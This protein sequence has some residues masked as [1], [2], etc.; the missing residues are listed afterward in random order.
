MSTRRSESTIRTARVV[1]QMST[2]PD[3][4]RFSVTESGTL[5]NS[6]RLPRTSPGYPFGGN[7]SLDSPGFLLSKTTPAGPNASLGELNGPS[8]SEKSMTIVEFSTK[9][10][11]PAIR[12]DAT[13]LFEKYES[14]TWMFPG[15]RE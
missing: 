9:L 10:P 5:R 2:H 6:I 14:T 4:P 15:H 8:Y 7:R 13:L 11:L 3:A 12:T 1:P